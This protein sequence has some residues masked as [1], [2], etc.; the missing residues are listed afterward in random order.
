[1]PGIGFGYADFATA[2][3]IE[4]KLAHTAPTLHVASV[5]ACQPVR[6]LEYF[7]DMSALQIF[8]DGAPVPPGGQLRPDLSRPGLGLELKRTEIERFAA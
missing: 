4:T 6:H 2:K 7:H 1:M 3:L 8:F 5:C